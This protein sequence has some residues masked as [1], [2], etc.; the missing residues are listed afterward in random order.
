MSAKAYKTRVLLNIKNIMSIITTLLP[1]FVI[2][3]LVLYQGDKA[4]N[5]YM[6]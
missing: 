3:E 1:R 4:L 5:L 2:T 6:T